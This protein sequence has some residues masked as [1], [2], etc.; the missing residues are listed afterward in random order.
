M[1]RS[2][3]SGDGMRGD[4]PR[5]IGNL[6]ADSTRSEPTE[7][8]E[9]PRRLR[10]HIPGFHG[11]R[12]SRHN[13]LRTGIPRW[14]PSR[15]QSK[16]KKL[17]AVHR[18]PWSTRTFFSFCYLS[19]PRD[20]RIPGGRITTPAPISRAW[21]GLFPPCRAMWQVVRDTPVKDGVWEL[22]HLRWFSGSHSAP[23]KQVP[24]VSCMSCSS[25]CLVHSSGICF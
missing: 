23:R 7:V 14:K 19:L 20:E 13:S 18:P 25:D 4:G 9:T 15:A 24:E 22:S 1:V 12:L 11:R 17:A 10:A 2:K 5:D 8:P 3:K 16:K 21:S 6:D